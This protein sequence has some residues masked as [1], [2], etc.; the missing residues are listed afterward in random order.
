MDEDGESLRSS[1]VAS[2]I[3]QIVSARMQN[4]NSEI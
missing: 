4:V 1:L 3:E 2:R